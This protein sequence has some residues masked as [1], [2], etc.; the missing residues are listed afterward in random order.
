MSGREKK[1]SS[2]AVATILIFVLL[3]AAFQYY[4]YNR[5][6]LESSRLLKSLGLPVQIPPYSSISEGKIRWVFFDLKMSVTTWEMSLDAYRYYISTPKPVERLGLGAVKGS[7][8]TYDLRPYIQPSFFRSVIGT[9]TSG[10]SDREFVKEVDNVK[11]QIVVYGKGLGNAPYRFS[12]ETLTEGKGTCADTTILMASMLVEGNRRGSYNF[13]V[14][15]CYVQ[16]SG[17]ALIADSQSITEANHVIV[18]IEFSNGERWSIETTTNY[19]FTYT[20]AFTGW[21][22]EVTRI[23]R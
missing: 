19:F 1:I 5:V 21:R 10:R 3:F 13:N 20:K 23:T 16:L 14:Y 22:F 11:N 4:G 12:A 2:S 7:I 9:L 18:Q 8:W 17:G 15:I 6:F